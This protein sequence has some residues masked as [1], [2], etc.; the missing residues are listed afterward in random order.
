[1]SAARPDWLTMTILVVEDDP[2]IGVPLV[3]RLT[4]DGYD[5]RLAQTAAHARLL[6]RSAP[7]ALLL[8][9]GLDTPA[10]S[11]A[12]L[13]EVRAAG[14]GDA[15]HDSAWPAG[16]PAIVIASA[17][18]EEEPSAPLPPAPTTSSP[19]QPATRSCGL[20]CALCLLA[21]STTAARSSAPVHSRSTPPR[22]P[23][24][25]TGAALPSAA[26]N[27]TCSWRSPA[28]LV[29]SLPSAT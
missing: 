7:P 16:L 29:A 14:D 5:A 12:L 24:T 22:M 19:D 9:G 10:A 1:M 3:E 28:T 11:L 23:R 2:L 4:A 27:T 15:N 20:A 18:G 25:C 17:S 8:L 26:S 21:P 13:G 6:A